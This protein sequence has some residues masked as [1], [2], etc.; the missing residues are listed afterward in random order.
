MAEK[1]KHGFGLLENVDAAIA[2]GTV[3]SYDILFVKDA[4]GKPYVGW[5]DKEGKK[6]ICDPYAEAA[7]VETVLEAEIAKKANAEDV[8][9]LEGKLADKASVESVSALETEMATKA[10]TED[11][12]SLGSQIAAKADAVDVAELEKEVATKVDA[13]TVENMIK[14][15]T[16]GVIEVVEF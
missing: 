14:E 9:T 11:V 7:K 12:E 8:E 4:E 3:D 6:V 5:V 1:A 16:V 10:N 15:A 2:S 13:T